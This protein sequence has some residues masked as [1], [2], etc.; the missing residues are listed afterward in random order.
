M[1]RDGQRPVPG[2]C[3]S[4][5]RTFV[6][7]LAGLG[8]AG[9]DLEWLVTR[10]CVSLARFAYSDEEARWVAAQDSRAQGQAFH[11]LWVL[12]EAAA[13]CLGLDLL[14]ALAGCRFHINGGRIDGRLPGAQEFQALLY[15][16]RPELRL[17][18]LTLSSDAVSAPACIEWVAGEDSRRE[19]QW[20]I[21]AGRLRA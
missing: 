1:I 5:S 10:D 18:W 9:V 14:A 4:H 2:A 16:P 13:K 21:V 20:P 7:C 17:A 15:A 8:N 3:L 11:E 12:K 19:V 6:A